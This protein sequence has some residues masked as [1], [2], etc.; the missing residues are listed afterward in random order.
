MPK[1]DD[2]RWPHHR[3][4]VPRSYYPYK[5]IMAYPPYH[6]NHDLPNSPVYPMWGTTGSHT[7]SMHTWGTPSYL[8]WPPAEIWHRKPYL[9]VTL[10]KLNTIIEIIFFSPCLA[11]FKTDGIIIFWNFECSCLIF[12][13]FYISDACGCMGLPCDAT[14]A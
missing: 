8:P 13:Y 12:A 10:V 11:C 9:G 6:S 2:R 7:A 3:E 4:Q 5:P 1:E 14:I